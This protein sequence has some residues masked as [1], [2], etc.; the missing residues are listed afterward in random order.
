MCLYDASVA[1]NPRLRMAICGGRRG[2]MVITDFFAAYNAVQR[3]GMMLKNVSPALRATR[4][5]VMRAVKTN[6][7]ALMYASDDLKSDKEVVLCA[8]RSNG[9]AIQ[10]ASP[11]LQSDGEVCDASIEQVAPSVPAS[12]ATMRYGFMGHF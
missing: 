3:S 5:L 10:Y 7:M 6:G 9:A 2:P 1:Q 12:E 4:E 11:E 8:V